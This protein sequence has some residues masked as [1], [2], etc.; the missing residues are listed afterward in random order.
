MLA[1]ELGA[2]FVAFMCE[3]G[4]ALGIAAEPIARDRGERE[5]RTVD[6]ASFHVLERFLRRPVAIAGKDEA[7]GTAGETLLGLLPAGRI[8]MV[9][10]VDAHERASRSLLPNHGRCGATRSTFDHS[11]AAASVREADDRAY[12]DLPLTRLS[13]MR[14]S[15]LIS[16]SGAVT[17]GLWLE[18]DLVA[19]PARR[20]TG[21]RR[22]LTEGPMLVARRDDIAARQSEWSVAQF[23]FLFHAF[24]RLG[25][26]LI[27]DPG[28]VLGRGV[29]GCR[30]GR[31]APP[32]ARFRARPLTLGL[33]LGHE[34]EK[35]LAV[36]R[37][38]GIEMMRC[39]MR[40]LARSATPVATIPP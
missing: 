14:S 4:G 25:Q 21:T 19:S 3:L 5:D 29:V 22:K 40:A 37:D 16:A 13:M 32:I 27:G 35:T 34:I 8:E 23:Q 30:V 38:E 9:M 24:E 1:R 28:A 18:F 20:A 39:A 10:R 17:L 36:L 2:V 6:A 15:T 11:D 7:A 33:L 26:A 31:D 12:A